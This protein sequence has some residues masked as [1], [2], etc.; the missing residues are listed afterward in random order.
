MDLRQLRAFVAVAE[1]L[2]FGRAARRLQM[3]QPALSQVVKRF[4]RELGLALFER[5]TRRVTLT[6]AGRTLLD[7]GR[8][9]LAAVNAA[10]DA[11][12]RTHSGEIGTLRI[13]LTTLAPHRLLPRLAESHGR[14]HPH[15]RLH[16]E[17]VP[18]VQQIERLNHYQLDAGL[19]WVPSHRGTLDLSQV[20]YRVLAYQR[21]VAIFP[22]RHPLASSTLLSMGQLAHEQWVTYIQV[23]GGSVIREAVGNAC[24]VA[25]FTPRIVQEAPDASSILWIVRA[26][27]GVTLMPECISDMLI[28]GVVAVPLDTQE[29]LL[30]FA[31]AWRADDNR[32]ILLGLLEAVFDLESEEFLSTALVD[33]E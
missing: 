27:V 18:S 29:P 25:G 26:G 14:R 17:N 7:H 9:I 24:H 10:E 23:P 19:L 13:G 16:P 12:R 5:T 22:S 4:E 8:D 1:E 6:D 33:E 15:V 3:A 2:H 20:T 31:L 32:A 30:K 21:L 28:P 11:T